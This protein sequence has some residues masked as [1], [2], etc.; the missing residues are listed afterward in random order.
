MT[1]RDWNLAGLSD[2]AE[3]VVS[4]LVTNA[5]RH[6]LVSA[7][8]IIEEH[9][10]GLRLLAQA[11]FV[12]CMVTDPGSQMPVRNTVGWLAESGRGLQVVESCSLRWGWQPLEA[13]GKVVWA[14]LEQDLRLAA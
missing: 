2:Q 13:G 1:L 11:P 4:E 12:T 6:G 10:V 9:P 3:L 7:R 14:L 5:I 8:R